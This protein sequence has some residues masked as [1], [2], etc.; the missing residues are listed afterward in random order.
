MSMQWNSTVVAKQQDS[1]TKKLCLGFPPHFNRT[2]NTRL[3]CKLHRC[4]RCLALR[5]RWCQRKHNGTTPRNPRRTEPSWPVHRLAANSVDAHT[6]QPPQSRWRTRRHQLQLSPPPRSPATSRDKHVIL[7]T[8]RDKEMKP[9]IHYLFAFFFL[10]LFFNFV[11][12]LFVL[13]LRTLSV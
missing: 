7:V 11:F 9:T 13:G 5:W 12:F 4:T 6:W 8:S 1:K 3:T 2:L 10:F